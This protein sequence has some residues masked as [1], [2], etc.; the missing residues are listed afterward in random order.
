M[1]NKAM[2][3]NLS[4]DNIYSLVRE[5]KWTNDAMLKMCEAAAADVNGDGTRTWQSDNFGLA[6]TG[7]TILGLFYSTGEKLTARDSDGYPILTP[8]TGRMAD[9]I[10]SSARILSNANLS[11]V[12]GIAP[13][14][15]VYAM[16]TMFEEGRALFY[17]EVMQCI[18]RMRGSDTDFGLIPW[19]KLD[20]AQ[21]GYYNLVHAT[22]AKAV[23]IP[24]TQR[25][26]EMAGALLE[27]MAAK[28]MY[29]LTP[30]YF[31]VSMTYKYMRDEESAEML[32][33]ILGS[34]CFDL[35]YIYNW[36][37]MCWNVAE[38]IAT[39]DT[40]TFASTWETFKGPFEA[41][42][43]TTIATYKELENR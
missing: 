14:A 40:G 10:V 3:E 13:E 34:R 28:S 29:T 11:V 41:A 9:A 32:S 20:E 23:N 35:G 26:P 42:L 25:N 19:P 4:L 2:H 43:N 21:S 16:E 6:T 38:P 37:D 24:A 18:T 15:D 5:G 8:D 22:A 31:D 12:A 30:A 1:F 39:G 27:A 17:G 36:G 33:I 7:M